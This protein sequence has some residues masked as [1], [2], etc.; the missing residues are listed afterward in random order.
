MKQH[1]NVFFKNISAGQ[2]QPISGLDL[3][4]NVME[5]WYWPDEISLKNTFSHC[6]ISRAVV[7]LTFI[8]TCIHNLFVNVGQKTGSLLS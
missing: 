4:I 6:F 3:E 8:H 5:G 1:E 7:H 2:Y